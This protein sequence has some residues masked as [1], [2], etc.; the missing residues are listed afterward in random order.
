MLQRDDFN[1]AVK[2]ALAARV[3]DL[4]SNPDCRALTSGPHEDPAKAVN[5][6]VAA[7]LT[8]AAP[9]GP[10]YDAALT[11]EQRASIENAIWLC[12]NHAKLIDS[13]PSRFT[14]A[15]LR[16]WK[17]R[18]EEEARSELGKAAAAPTK[19]TG[20][21]VYEQNLQ[22]VI[23][24]AVVSGAGSSGTGTVNIY[25][26]NFYA[27]TPPPSSSAV[28][29]KVVEQPAPT[30]T[31]VTGRSA[32]R[33][34]VVL[35][36]HVVAEGQ[37]IGVGGNVWT[38]H[39]YRLLVGDETALSHIAD[40]NAQF[41]LGDRCIVLS[42]PPGEARTIVG[43]MSWRR[44]AGEG[45]EI[46]VSVAPPAAKRSVL[47]LESTDPETMRPVKGVAAGSTRFHTLLGTA[48]GQ[49]R[50]GSGT[51]ISEW[52]RV[53]ELRPRLA[54]LVRM[55]ILRLAS[56]PR[57][58]KI[59]SEAHAPLAHV[60]RVLSVEM[61]PD[62]A[63][64]IEVSFV[65][66]GNWKGKVWLAI[67][68]F[69]PPQIESDRHLEGPLAAM[70]ASV[71]HERRKRGA[72]AVLPVPAPS[73]ATVTPVEAP[74]LASVYLSYGD[75]DQPFARRLFE[76]LEAAGVPV[77]YRHE[78]AVPGAKHHR[79]ARRSIREYEHVILLCSERSL[80]AASVLSELDE[81][82]S[83]EFDEG[84]AERI[85]PILLDDFASTGWQ[86]RHPD[87]RRAVRDR[88]ALDMKGA[89]ADRSKFEKALKRLL[90]ALNG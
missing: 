9:G 89:E 69:E 52:L 27:G 79:S 10:R 2:R 51:W 12:Q 74:A 34:L 88:V 55:E 4:C 30:T 32:Q 80:Q 60:D 66:G 6:G 22:G 13:D 65:G 16:E 63:A 15:L 64:E 25:A 49:L 31:V 46:N 61:H 37:R 42:V 35:G 18:A 70:R 43:D 67:E 82:L 83:R 77:F 5:L 57:T 40:A 21:A 71:E 38:V 59:T 14:V 85:I 33:P 58:N 23:A 44:V 26:Q 72:V 87:L 17:T 3:G 78:H 1:E 8:A 39:L 75:D 73:L 36:P 53:P 84:A 48:L 28:P 86:P 29:E 68:P 62:D 45:F 11:P 41:F 50:G 54:D 19:P 7:H 76:G 90:G 47:D 81:M 56:V 20:P 24:G